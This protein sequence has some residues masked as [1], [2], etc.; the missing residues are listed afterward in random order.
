L[1]DL[2]EEDVPEQAPVELGALPAAPEKLP[3]YKLDS[4]SARKKREEQAAKEAAKEEPKRVASPVA[5]RRQPAHMAERP[6]DFV[7]PQF[8]RELP[9]LNDP[10]T[11]AARRRRVGP[12][13][14]REK[15]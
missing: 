3:W 7:P 14:R 9:P 5:G 6:P 11:F 12:F 8:V 2:V 4:K 1:P 13:G 15:S 10:E